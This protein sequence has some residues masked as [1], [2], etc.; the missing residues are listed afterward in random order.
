MTISTAYYQIFFWHLIGDRP[1]CHASLLFPLQTFYSR[2]LFSW[3]LLMH[4]VP[5]AHAVFAIWL[6]IRHRLLFC[7]DHLFYVWALGSRVRNFFFFSSFLFISS[8]SSSVAKLVIYEHLNALCSRSGPFAY[9][10]CRVNRWA[11][12]KEEWWDQSDSIKMKIKIVHLKKSIHNLIGLI[13]F[14]VAVAFRRH[15]R[16][17]AGTQQSNSSIGY[18]FCDHG[19]SDTNYISRPSPIYIQRNSTIF[20]FSFFHSSFFFCGFFGC[21]RHIARCPCGLVVAFIITENCESINAVHKYHSSMPNRIE[22]LFFFF[23]W[24]RRRNVVGFVVVAAA[25]AAA[26]AFVVCIKPVIRRKSGSCSFDAHFQIK[27]RCVLN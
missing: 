19:V 1:H 23:G 20:F 25:V 11:V 2:I 5:G 10:K 4:C 18:L 21:I 3:C 16:R 15:R 14:V 24:S 12:D 17:S 27:F 7:A 13:I 6:Y 9:I 8:S 26:V 22:Y